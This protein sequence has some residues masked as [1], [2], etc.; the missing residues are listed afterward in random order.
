MKEYNWLIE[1]YDQ[2]DKQTL[3]RLHV[4]NAENHIRY[5]CHTLE[6]PW[7]NNKTSVSCIPVGK[8]KVIKHHSP[9]FGKCFWIQDV[10]KRSE[11]LV[12]RGNYHTQIRGCILPGTDL[13]DI[14]KDRLQDVINSQAAIEDLLRIM[15]NEFE[16]KIVSFI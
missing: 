9:R 1:R 8:Y 7:L 11:I 4:V 10:D 12:H 6:L 14:N 13:K 2:G 5:S 15:P 16:L 3:G